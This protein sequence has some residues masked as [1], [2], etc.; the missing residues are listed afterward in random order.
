MS[1]TVQYWMIEASKDGVVFDADTFLQG[2][3]RRD[4]EDLATELQGAHPEGWKPEVV[5]EVKPLTHADFI[6]RLLA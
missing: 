2:V 5:F 3:S 4:A 6:E 1:A